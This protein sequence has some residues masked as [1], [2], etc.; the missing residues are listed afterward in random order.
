[1]LKHIDL[2]IKGIEKLTSPAKLSEQYK[3]SAALT[4]QILADREKVNSVIRGE[5]DR[6]IAIVGP[7]SIHDPKSALEYAKRLKALSDQVEDKLLI[8]MRTY[9]KR[10]GGGKV[11]IRP[12][13]D[14]SY[15]KAGIA[16]QENF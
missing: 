10:T 7:C 4:K 11:N 16:Q 1:M 8:V 5:D 14:S 13:L 2:R 12:H 15:V 6:L 9:L 3:V